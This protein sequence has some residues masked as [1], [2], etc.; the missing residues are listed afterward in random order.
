MERDV[1]ELAK[2]IQAQAKTGLHFVTNDYELERYEQIMDTTI[3]LIAQLSAQEPERIH[4]ALHSESLYVTPKVD[5]RTVVFDDKGRFLLVKEK[6]DGKWTL[7]GGFCDVGFSPSEV[8]VKETWEEAGI[9]V[10][11]VRLL[12]VLDKRKHEHPKTL[13][14]L[15]T[16]FMLCEKVGGVEQPGSETLDVQYFALDDLPE[17]STYRV[18]K[19]QLGMMEP[20][21]HNRDLEPYF[22]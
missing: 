6:V 19:R 3:Q 10:R 9:N 16:I 12:G 15:Y 17:L 18:T 7:P 20:F 2:M 21:F 8:A 11:P 1:L 14:Y 4:M 13:Y 5:L 22:D